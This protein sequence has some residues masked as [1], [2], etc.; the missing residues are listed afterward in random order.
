MPVK[1]NSLGVE[2]GAEEWPAEEAEDHEQ[3]PL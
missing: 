2:N 3:D 1:K